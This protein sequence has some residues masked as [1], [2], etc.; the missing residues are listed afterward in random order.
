[1]SVGTGVAV[2]LAIL[3]VLP[4]AAV[5]LAGRWKDPPRSRW[6]ASERDRRLAA[7]D[8]G[9]AELRIRRAY[10][11]RDEDRWRA[12][13]RAV[14]RGEA[15]PDDLRPAA[16]AL[17]RAV[18]DAVD[19]QPTHWTPPAAARIP[20]LVLAVVAIGF[21]LVTRPELGV[22]YLAYGLAA[23]LTRTRWSPAHRRVA[24]AAA[25]HANSPATP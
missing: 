22:V 16:V 21:L 5:W 8:L 11:L 23:F 13:H 15:A 25:L 19:S 10:G 24:A 3:L 7:G 4:V 18:I 12:V 6:G 17:A 20:L 1:M 14:R 9:L 2:V